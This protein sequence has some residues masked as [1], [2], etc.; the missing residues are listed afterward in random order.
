MYINLETY[1]GGDENSLSSL[2][3]EVK[4]HYH[5]EI[6]VINR[7]LPSMCVETLKCSCVHFEDMLPKKNYAAAR[8]HASGSVRYYASVS[9]RKIM[10]EA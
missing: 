2:K 8:L 9:A 1:D 4:Y 6:T 10:S 5:D 7:Q 3:K